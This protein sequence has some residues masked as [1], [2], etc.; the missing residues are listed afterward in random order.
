MQARDE[1][2]NYRG[3]LKVLKAL[4]ENLCTNEQRQIKEVVTTHYCFKSEIV[5][6]RPEGFERSESVS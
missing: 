5:L 2:K 1:L 4:E 3:D 6:P